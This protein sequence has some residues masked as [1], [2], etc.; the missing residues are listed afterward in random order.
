MDNTERIS[1]ISS[2]LCCILLGDYAP[3]DLSDGAG[4][5]LL[6]LKTLVG[7]G[8]R[9]SSGCGSSNPYSPRLCQN[10]SDK[11][12][13]YISP[14]TRAQLGTPVP[15]YQG[16]VV[17]VPAITQRQ[18]PPSPLPS[19]WHGQPRHCHQVRPRCGL[20][21]RAL[22]RRQ[23]VQVRKSI[24]FQSSNLFPTRFPTSLTL[25]SL[26]G[27]GLKTPGDIGVSLGTSDTLFSI[28]DKQHAKPGALKFFCFTLQPSPTSSSAFSL[29]AWRATSSPTPWT[30]TRT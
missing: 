28:I 15:A 10:W 14:N 23:P 12:A 16:E 2:F 26:A 3:I 11:I 7:E 24:F 13:N 6:D 22:V 9:Q 27:L 20:P 1:L 17:N 8:V 30:P 19:G 4:M 5:N 21:H 29:Q 18:N 25:P